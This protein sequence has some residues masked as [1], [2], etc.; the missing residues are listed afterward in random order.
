MLLARSAPVTKTFIL[1]KRVKSI[2]VGHRH[3]L[4]RLGVAFGLRTQNL[5]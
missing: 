1:A 2:V 5:N 3:K 4:K